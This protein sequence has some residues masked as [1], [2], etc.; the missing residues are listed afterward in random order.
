MGH[1]F[2]DRAKWLGPVP[3]CHNFM[4]IN[5]LRRFR[6]PPG[7]QHAPRPSLGSTA[8]VSHRKALSKWR[9]RRL[10]QSGRTGHLGGPVARWRNSFLLNDLLTR[11]II[12][13]KLGCAVPVRVSHPA[14]HPPDCLS[15]RREN[16]L[17]FYSP[18]PTPILLNAFRKPVK[19]GRTQEA[20]VRRPNTWRPHSEIPRIEVTGARRHRRSPPRALAASFCDASNDCGECCGKA[21]SSPPSACASSG[22]PEWR[23]L[24]LNPRKR[25]CRPHGVRPPAITWAAACLLPPELLAHSARKMPP[26]V[27]PPVRHPPLALPRYD[28][29][30]CTS[31]SLP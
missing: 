11:F 19:T 8:R 30:G 12:L 15:R 9:L 16:R 2:P 23:Y 3:C 7:H 4:Q 1:A 13:C 20:K 27:R 17:R 14:R 31:Q 18:L 28:R 22:P 25:I 10:S 24:L 5:N 26:S 29:M 21:P 6:G